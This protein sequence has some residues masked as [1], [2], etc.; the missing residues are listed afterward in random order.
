M[1]K[2]KFRE[3]YLNIENNYVKNFRKSGG[4]VIGYSY[5]RVPVAEVYHAAGILGIRLRANE[6]TATTLGDAYFGPVVCS[7]PKSLLQMAGEGKY[8]FLD[9][10]VTSSVCD[11]TRRLDECWRRA[12][13]EGE[14]SIPPFFKY[15]A[16]PHKALDFSLE[17]FTEELRLHISELESHF[18]VRV[19][20]EALNDSI[21]LYNRG[22]RLLKKLDDL[23]GRPEVPIS[24]ADALTVFV[25]AVSMPMA[26]FV[27]MAEALLS[28]LEESGRTVP[29]KRLFM[30]GSVNDDRGLIESIEQTGA[31]VVG[32][33]TSFGSKYYDNMI[34]EDSD[35]PVA[36]IA[37]AYL[38][39][40]KHPRMF[41][42]FRERSDFLAGMVK[43]SRAQGVVF[44]N[45]RFCDLHGCENSLFAEELTAMG[46]PCLRLEREYGPLVETER[47]K[48]RAQAFVERI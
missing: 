42:R 19:S 43:Q 16:V 17:W 40:L 20:K 30:V 2:E 39:N 10:A 36:E 35:D 26:P 23:R 34:A 27:Q 22:R 46:I 8:R 24:G 13:R 9:G 25:A 21:K 32:D 11:T 45:I 31:V 48:M 7:F 5:S 38:V 1:L 44:Q 15:F 14:A 37:R 28:E 12:A 41:G 29:G 4:K 3:V 47:V 6:I 33:M 18:D